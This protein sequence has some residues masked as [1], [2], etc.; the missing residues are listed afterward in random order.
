MVVGDDVAVF[1]DEE[2]GALSDGA[3]RAFTF[4]VAIGATLVFVCAGATEF[5]EK[6]LQRMVVRK[7]IQTA[8][9]EGKTAAVVR[10]R[11]DI[12]FD[13]DRNDCGRNGIN[14][15]GKARYLG[16]IHLDRCCKGTGDWASDAGGQHQ[17]GKTADGRRLQNC[18]QRRA[19][20]L[21]LRHLISFFLH[22]TGA[23]EED[24]SSG[25]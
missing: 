11:L 23:S 20:V 2:A 15:A 24:R 21:H 5:L 16:C 9:A 18:L 17:R 7:L 6:A 22:L 10:N 8:T 13:A 1:R 14:D 25:G 19:S 12:G 4:A 3:Q